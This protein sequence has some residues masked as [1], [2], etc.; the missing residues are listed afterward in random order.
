MSAAKELL[1][2]AVSAVIAGE[3]VLAVIVGHKAKH[4]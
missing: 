2:G 3:F 1:I 4:R